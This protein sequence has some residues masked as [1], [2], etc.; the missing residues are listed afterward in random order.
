L[1]VTGVAPGNTQITVSDAV[2]ATVKLSVTV[3]GSGL[4]LSTTAP[5][6]IT[7]VIG[8]HPSYTISGGTAPYTA[9]SSNISIAT[10]A[11]ATVAGV[12]TLTVTGVA[13]GPAANVVVRDALNAT[14]SIT[15][16][17]TASA[18]LLTTA[19]S[20]AVTIAVGGAESYTIGGGTGSYSVVSSN[21]AVATASLPSA[22]TLNIVGKS[23]GSAQ[24]VV[25]DA[26]GNS[27]TVA[28]TVVS[29]IGS[30]LFTT[31]PVLG[32]I[33]AKNGTGVYTIGGGTPFV[34]APAYKASTSNASVATVSVVGSSLTISGAAEGTATVSVSDSAGLAVSIPVTIGSG[35]ALFSTAPSAVA[36]A[37][38]TPQTY[39]MGGGSAPYVVTSSSTSI[40]TV[41]MP[42]PTAT[43]F[44]ITGVAAG[45]AKV[46]V[47]DQIGKSVSIDVTVSLGGASPLFTT[48]PGSVASCVIY[49]SCL[50]IAALV[51]PTY[52][53]GGG[54]APY[55]ATSSDVTKVTA[56]VTGTALNIAG[57]AAG[58]A[59][60]QVS[61]ALGATV[62]IRVTVTAPVASPVPLAVNPSTSTA[63]VGDVLSFAISGGSPTYSVV[64]TAPTVA[65]VSTSSVFVN[66]GT[67]NATMLSAGVTGITITDLTGQTSTVNLTVGAASGALRV[68]PSSLQVGEDYA[69]PITLGIVGGTPP[70][71]FATT[72]LVLSTVPLVASS[73][74]VFVVTVGSQGTRCISVGIPA[75]Q[76][77]T[78]T[79]TVTDALLASTTSTLV[80]ADNGKGDGSNKCGAP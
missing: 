8:A 66:G 30:P 69:A 28:V 11:T 37:I 10:S 17:V 60:V 67:F 16:N 27:V 2:G 25:F 5:G 35:S 29:P 6:A 57:I 32:V 42:S 48:A 68:Y 71:S 79:L 7:L 63:R 78:I 40:A 9:T 12:T 47:L 49:N 54:T 1:V 31:A 23:A 43:T 61:D 50:T 65:S 14:V 4:P 26:A 15:V 74:S 58:A 46:V 76:T 59:T 52:V 55:A 33:I 51:S 72:D 13:S 19:P 44:T 18:A 80:I 75:S 21:T 24:V 36:V 45:T 39:S 53:V 64:A 73:S 62:L 41:S 3:G 20:N 56:S 70:Y 34:V 77:H 22:N 38:G